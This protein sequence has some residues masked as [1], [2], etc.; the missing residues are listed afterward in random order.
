MNQPSLEGP[1]QPPARNAAVQSCCQ[2]RQRSLQQS[3]QANAEYLA[4][5]IRASEAY[6]T[7]MPDLSGYANIGDFIACVAHGML[8]G[9]ISPIEGPKLLY[10]AQVAIGALRQKPAAAPPTPLPSSN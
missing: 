7:A 10:A 5:K 6:C 3:E 2:A 4:T 9:A 1:S 8:N